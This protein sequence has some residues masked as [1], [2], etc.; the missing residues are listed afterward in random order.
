MSG[1]TFVRITNKD[2]F[3]KVEELVKS[4]NKINGTVKVHSWAIGILVLII[5]AM[6]KFI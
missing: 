6:I 5:V 3:D 2:I 1:K 4:I